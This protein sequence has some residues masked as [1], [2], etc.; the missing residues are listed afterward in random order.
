MFDFKAGDP[1][2]SR[3]RDAE[4][5]AAADVLAQQH[6]EIRRR[7]GVGLLAVG[8]VHQRKRSARA[9][10]KPVVCPVVFDGEHDGIRLRLIYFIDSAVGQFLRQL[11]NEIR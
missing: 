1:L 10:Q 8:Q 11:I 6:A 7:H 3:L 5:A 4:D 2:Q 9:D